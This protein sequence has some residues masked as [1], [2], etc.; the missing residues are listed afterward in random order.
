VG[1]DVLG[2]L[3]VRGAAKDDDVADH[4]GWVPRSKVYG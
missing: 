3:R 1:A 4:G 2:K